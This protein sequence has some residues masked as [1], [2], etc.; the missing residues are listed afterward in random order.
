MW[1]APLALLLG[2]T[3]Q[4]GIDISTR[5][6]PVSE[7]L[8][9]LSAKTG[10]TLR[11]APEL[12]E[13]IVFVQV[14]NAPVADLESRLATALQA[15]WT[16]DRGGELLRRT[17]EDAKAIWN[18]HVRYRRKLVDAAL[19]TASQRLAQPFDAQVLATSLAAIKPSGDDPALQT[20]NYA[21]LRTLSTKG[22]MARLI[23]RLALACNPD[24][25]AAVG[26]FERHVFR[27]E[28]T[29]M[30]SGFDPDRL[31]DA[32]SAFAAE[33]SAWRDAAS[34]VTFPQDPGGR[35]VSDPR[36]Q[37]DR[38]PTL[39]GTCLE[40]KRGEMSALFMLN[41]LDEGP[42]ATGLGVLSQA[43]YAD[44]ARTF[45]D[46][47]GTPAAPAGDDPLVELGDA[48]K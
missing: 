1:I 10:E 32:Q 41:L 26:P 15:H 20:Q 46:A 45:L 28:P 25:L 19:K 27:A 2:S 38:E 5:A 11:V 39:A 12:A 9:S 31:R 48:G 43:V 42:G 23:D 37:V 4:A 44:P 24:D 47:Q 8:K 16:A 22:P 3:G 13:S 30:Q 36:T 17:P 29:V 21:K 33:Q 34:R 18:E 14:H 40:V 35:M 6:V 7:F